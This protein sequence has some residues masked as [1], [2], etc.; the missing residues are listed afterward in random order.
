MLPHAPSNRESLAFVD[1]QSNRFERILIAPFGF[2]KQRTP[3]LPRWSRSQLVCF[4]FP[5]NILMITNYIVKAN[6]ILSDLG[7]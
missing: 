6:F 7:T 4:S 5:L 1:V 2:I 3:M